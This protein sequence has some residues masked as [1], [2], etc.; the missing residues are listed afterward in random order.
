MDSHVG[1]T[2]VIYYRC[3]HMADNSKSHI[4]FLQFFIVFTMITPDKRFLF[5]IVY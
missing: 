4:E 3:H 5:K 1:P 2:T